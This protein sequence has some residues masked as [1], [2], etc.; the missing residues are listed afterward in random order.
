[1]KNKKYTYAEC[2]AL[3]HSR[4]DCSWEQ[5]RKK[6]KSLVQKWHPDRTNQASGNMNQATSKVV[7]INIAYQQLEQYYKKEGRLPD[8]GY[9]RN[10]SHI[11][12]SVYKESVRTN[13]TTS[14]YSAGAKAHSSLNSEV[15]PAASINLK[16]RA[17]SLLFLAGFSYIGFILFSPNSSHIQSDEKTSTIYHAPLVAEHLQNDSEAKFSLTHSAIPDKKDN[18]I[19]YFTYGSKIGD[20]VI[21]QGP[22][23]NIKDNVWYYGTSEVH[24]YEGVVTRWVRNPNFPLYARIAPA[25]KKADKK[26][27]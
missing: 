7:E 22:P 13:N 16:N 3:L 9:T 5:L 25:S 11:H 1:M 4:P 24:F 27:K 18:K 6:Y 21:A 14:N 15:K 17:K 12:S 20:V 8:S 2:F 23:D 10:Q 26:N 19:H